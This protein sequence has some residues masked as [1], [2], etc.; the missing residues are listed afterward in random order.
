MS[1]GYYYLCHTNYSIC[2]IGTSVSNASHVCICH[3]DKVSAMVYEIVWLVLSVT[4]ASGQGE[5]TRESP[6]LG[7]GFHV[8]CRCEMMLLLSKRAVSGVTGLSLGTCLFPVVFFFFKGSLKGRIELLILEKK[9][10]PFAEVLWVI[11]CPKLRLIGAKL[12]MGEEG[13]IC[14]HT[15]HRRADIWYEIQFSS[16]KIHGLG[17]GIRKNPSYILKALLTH[18]GHFKL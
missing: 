7:L 10:R 1:M 14:A 4:C 18:T 12:L 16:L 9:M 8:C 3:V 5:P 11:W 13:S 6:A 17:S 2:Y 15:A